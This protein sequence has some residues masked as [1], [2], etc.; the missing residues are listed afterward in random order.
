MFGM[1]DPGGVDVAVPGHALPLLREEVSRS[2]GDL[3]TLARCRAA[4]RE[5]LAASMPLALAALAAEHQAVFRGSAPRCRIAGQCARWPPKPS[6]SSV[7][8]RCR[9]TC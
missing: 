5:G 8:R 9:R 3:P 7:A 6:D 4:S 2:G 1:Q